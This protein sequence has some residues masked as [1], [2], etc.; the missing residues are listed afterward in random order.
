ML[1]ENHSIQARN[2]ILRQQQGPLPFTGK[3]DF[4]SF[5]NA[6][7]INKI[8]NTREN[9]FLFLS[10]FNISRNDNCPLLILPLNFTRAKAFYQIRYFFEGDKSFTSFT[11][12]T[13]ST[14]TL[15]GI[16]AGISDAGIFLGKS[17][18]SAITNPGS[19][20]FL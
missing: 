14:L 4:V 1:L 16:T 19:S 8:F 12:P 5:R 17:R 7:G 3:H 6:H 13:E 20:P 10:L 9:I 18:D 11:L 2:L 15:T